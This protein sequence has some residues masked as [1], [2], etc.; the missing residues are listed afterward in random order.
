[1]KV[2]RLRAAANGLRCRCPD[3]GGPFLFEEGHLFRV[4][5]RCPRCG[6]A[7]QRGDGAFLGPFVI[8]YGVTAFGI[9]IPVLLLHLRGLFGTQATFLI[10]AAGALL[11]PLAFYRVS[12]GWWLALY[13]FFL[14][15]SLP[16]NLEGG[17][18]EDE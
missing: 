9:V 10:S 18:E 3:C 5:D 4:R 6:L 11:F 17:S 15:G 16:D 13:F 7:F 8:N 1:V 14:P 2:T 12:W